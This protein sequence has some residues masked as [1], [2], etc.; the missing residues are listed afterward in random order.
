M[1]IHQLSPLLLMLQLTA[2]PN[3]LYRGFYM[4]LHSMPGILLNQHYRL[5]AILQ[6]AGI[7]DLVFLLLFKL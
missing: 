5:L 1:K 6:L 3:D 4:F 7:I 2:G